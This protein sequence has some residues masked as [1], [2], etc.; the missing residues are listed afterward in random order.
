[1]REREVAG[2]GVEREEGGT[3]GG[4]IHVRRWKTDMERRRVKEEEGMV[5]W[6]EEKNEISVVHG[7]SVE[8]V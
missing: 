3:G 8:C 5:E 4:G 6:E 1:M 2:G 7:I